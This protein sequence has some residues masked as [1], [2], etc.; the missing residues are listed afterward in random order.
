MPIPFLSKKRP[1]YCAELEI[2]QHRQQERLER[3]VCS[4]FARGNISLQNG[5]YF[6]PDDMDILQSELAEYFLQH[7]YNQG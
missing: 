2:K 3:E 5:D 1:D 7:K 6:T 4:A